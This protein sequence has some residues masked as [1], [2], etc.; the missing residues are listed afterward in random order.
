[1]FIT[2]TV[3]DT[4]IKTIIITY[5]YK[6]L[7]SWSVRSVRVFRSPRTGS[8]IV[9]RFSYFFFY[10][11]YLVFAWEKKQNVRTEIDLLARKRIPGDD[12]YDYAIF[13]LSPPPPVVSENVYNNSVD[14]DPYIYLFVR[15]KR[16]TSNNDN[17]DRND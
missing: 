7:P 2:C 17:N 8:F 13:C 4:V 9:R 11:L 14:D 16:K 1:V 12:Y 10:L 15:R 5:L 3:L 6:L